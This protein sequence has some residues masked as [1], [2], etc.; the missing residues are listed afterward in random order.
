MGSA[1]AAHLANAG[2][3]SLML[4]IVPP[5]V[6]EG[7]DP[8]DPVFRNRF[9][10][11]AL[12]AALNARPAPFYRKNL[13]DLIE[14]GNFDDDFERIAE[15][16]WIIEVVKE[17]LEIK[18]SVLSRVAEH[19]RP[20]SLVSSNTSGITIGAMA[21]GLDE[22]FRRHFLGTHFFNPPRYLYLLEIIPTDDTDKGLLADFI[23][24][25]DRILG[26]GIVQAKDTPNFVANRIGVFGMMDAIA[27]MGEQKLGVEEI[28]FLTGPIVGHPKS[29][30]FRTADLVGL[31]TFVA[32]AGNVYN[33]CPN[34]ESREIFATPTILK[35]MLEAGY[36]G[37]KTGGGF[38]KKSKDAE[39]NRVIMTLDLDSMD[40]R[41]KQRPKFPELEAIRNIEDIGERLPAL[42]GSKGRAAEFTWRTLSRLFQYCAFRIGEIADDPSPIDDGMRWGFGWELGPF[43]KWDILGFTA[44][45]K[46]MKEEGLELPAWIETML[47]KKA[48]GFYKI[49]GGKVSIWDPST[50]DYKERVSDPGRITLA[51]LKAAGATIKS[52]AGASIVDLGDGVACLEFHSK[53]NTLGPD[54]IGMVSKA[55]AEVQANYD[56]LV[57]ANQGE[58]FS[59]GANLML[60]LQEALE[61]EWDDLN[62]MIAGFQ[63]ATMALKYAPVPTVVAPH[64]LCLGGGAEFVLHGQRTR[65]SAETYI[66]LVEVGAGVLPAGGGCKELYLRTLDRHSNSKDLL[67][68]V[69][70]TFETIG[71]AKVAT[72]ALEAR[73]FG[74]MRE[75]DGFSINRERLVGDA[76]AAVISMV[77]EGWKAGKPLTKIPVMG[78]AGVAVIESVLHNMQDGKFISEHDRKIGLKVGTI[79]C[80]GDLTGKQDVSEQYLLDLERE[81]FLSLLGERKSL[82]RMQAILKT[83]KPLRN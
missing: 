15:A 18:R 50:G 31:D 47:E 62:I 67:P 48:D 17:D 36:L 45:A 8:K 46:R 2:I 59:V 81:H 76:K 16:D 75:S 20:G 77:K 25:S 64:G 19:R 35:N 14:I 63:R 49:E 78:R 10:A 70:K 29:A 4:D 82:E 24:F 27:A 1:I 39:G 65:A 44:T 56:G 53:M 74:F 57:V 5:Q 22:D 43:Q 71:M 40:Y 7:D 72:S 23:D 3:P 51:H 42:L 54:I 68:V 11:S 21:E 12:K 26:K 79:I 69:Q 37:D 38:Y 13:S 73:D 32:V 55:V 60:V 28:D 61:Q 33:G 52:N 58:N 83:G 66:G 34:D 9:A 41:E 30:S 80:G 6:G